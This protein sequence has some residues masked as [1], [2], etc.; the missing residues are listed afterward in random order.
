MTHKVPR[1]DSEIYGGWEGV[2]N[3]KIIRYPVINWFMCTRMRVI[4][5]FPMRTLNFFFFF[6]NNEKRDE[7]ITI[8]SSTDFEN[9]TY[10]RCKT[11]ASK[12]RDICILIDPIRTCKAIATWIYFVPDEALTPNVCR[13]TNIHLLSRL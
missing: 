8:S 5:Y 12:G 2:E 11:S 9:T 10:R 3:R 6:I 4:L 13:Q 7:V 1:V